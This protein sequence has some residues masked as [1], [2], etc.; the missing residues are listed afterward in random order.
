MLFI[1]IYLRVTANLSSGEIVSLFLLLGGKVISLLAI[2]SKKSNCS[3][4][5]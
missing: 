4:L 3:I 1:N 2:E 5:I